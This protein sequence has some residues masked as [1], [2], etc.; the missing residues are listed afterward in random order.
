MA[1]REKCGWRGAASGLLLTC[2][3]A[4]S[5]PAI[6]Q[7]WIGLV[8]GEMM[9]RGR[10][11]QQEQLCMLGSAP[12]P[13]EVS[14]VRQPASLAMGKYWAMVSLGGERDIASVFEGDSDAGWSDGTRVLKKA[15]AMPVNDRFA[16]AGAQFESDPAFLMRSG[17]G[18]LVRA[19]F[20]V[21]DA[22]GAALG[23]YDVTL[24]RNLGRWHLRRVELVDAAVAPEGI[25]QFCHKEGDVAPYRAAYAENARKKAARDDE[26]TRLKAA[27]RGGL[28]RGHAPPAANN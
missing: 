20:R 9:A 18:T 8:V 19:L 25:E 26:K 27:K 23:V 5:A 12:P 7:A 28:D 4:L 13:G 2:T 14:E 10:A 22:S 17:D 1:F 21:K 15:K 16:V 24:R 3:F 6:G 11:A